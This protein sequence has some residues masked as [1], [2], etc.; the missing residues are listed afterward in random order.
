MGVVSLWVVGVPP[1]NE[2]LSQFPS[3][4]KDLRKEGI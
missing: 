4:C 2:A 1:G 3:L